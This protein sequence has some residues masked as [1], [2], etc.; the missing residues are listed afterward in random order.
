MVI[1]RW[2]TSYERHFADP[3][4]AAKAGVP[5]GRAGQ[6]QDIANGVLFLASD[7][8]SYMNGAEP[9][10]DEAL[11]VVSDRAGAESDFSG[12]LQ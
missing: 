1:K 10:I 2:T 3:N 5:L 9:I 11:P 6:A 12:K 8:S 4:E 7:T